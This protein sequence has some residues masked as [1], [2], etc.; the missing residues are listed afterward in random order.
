MEQL[1]LLLLRV[2]LDME[3][4]AAKT[5]RIGASQLDVV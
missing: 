4:M 1:Q 3:V 2:S 5:F